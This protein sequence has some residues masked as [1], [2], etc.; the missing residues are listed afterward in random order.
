M[1]SLLHLLLLLQDFTRKKKQINLFKGRY[2]DHDNI[3]QIDPTCLGDIWLWEIKNI[4][5]VTSPDHSTTNPFDILC[6][7][8]V[9]NPGWVGCGLYIYIYLIVIICFCCWRVTSPAFSLNS[10]KIYAIHFVRILVEY[11][12]NLF[13]FSLALQYHCISSHKCMP[14]KKEVK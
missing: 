9:S 11:T 10:I 12:G 13:L 5:S 1:I 7:N 3:L 4:G 6:M 2:I 8:G 14:S